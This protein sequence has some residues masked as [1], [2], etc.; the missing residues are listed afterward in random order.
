MKGFIAAAA[1]LTFS[2]VL[3]AQAPNPTALFDHPADSWPS[4][5]G[6]Y[7]GRRY[8]KLKKINDQNI[9]HLSLG[10][11]YH[12]PTT[13][14]G[15]IKATPL[16][17][18]G[19]LYFSAPDHVWAVDARTG[20]ELWHHEWESSGG[21]HIGN[22][23]VALYGNTVYYETPDCNL[24]ALDVND[25]SERWHTAICDL[26]QFY[27]GSVAP[28]I[29]NNQV[30]VGVSGDDLDRP[31]YVQSHDPETGAVKW[32]W[33]VTPQKPGDPGADSWPNIEIAKNGGG[34]TW[35]PITFDPELNMIYFGTGNPQPVV[36]H[37]NRAGK[38]L[39]TESIVALDAN[40]GKMKWYF[41]ASP[42]DTHDWDATEAAVLFDGEIDGEPRKLLAQASRNGY[43]FVLDR[44]TGEN[45]VSKPFIKVNWSLG[46]NERGEPIP[47]PQKYPQVDGALVTPNQGGATNW[48][49]PAFNPD[50]GLF[51][52]DAS[53]AYSVWYIYDT[54]ANPQGWGGTD[55]GGYS[56]SSVKAI[57]Y[58]TGEVRWTHHWE[59]AARTGLLTTAG[60]LV[61]AG[62]NEQNIVALDAATGEALW[63][64]GLGARVSNGP[65]T[66]ELDG[67]QYLTVGAGNAL[68]SFVMWSDD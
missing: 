64:A 12:I 61:F 8:S 13:G 30:I 60:N 68:Y 5:H 16:M 18:N 11:V 10:W 33:Y 23:G 15:S 21:M 56:T 38:N 24:V 44:E 28:T 52:T 59:G 45:I 9:R 49:P 34:M 48:E 66:Y 37:A 51:Y 19:I 7:S 29:V 46:V 39:F 41:Q 53:Q 54:S 62:D 57:D 31:G 36:A 22:R 43:F 58:K 14:R 4:Y 27:F 26:D 42:H 63:H 3:G 2:G 67:D 47:D 25:G 35:Q 32:R 55:R 50:T 17:V 1:V 20:G 40:S 65:I 6:D